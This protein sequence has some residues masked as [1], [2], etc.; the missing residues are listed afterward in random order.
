MYVWTPGFICPRRAYFI[1]YLAVDSLALEAEGGLLALVHHLLE[2]GGLAEG[3]R[4]RGAHR[5]EERLAV[6]LGEQD[7]AAGLVMW[8]GWGWCVRCALVPFIS[9]TNGLTFSGPKATRHLPTLQM[10]ERSVWQCLKK[11]MWKTGSASLMCP[12]WPAQSVSFRLA[13]SMGMGWMGVRRGDRR[14]PP[15][16][17]LSQSIRR[18]QH[19]HQSKRTGNLLYALAGGAGGGLVRHA[20]SRVQGRVGRRRA[21]HR[22]VVIKLKRM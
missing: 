2:D 6:G 18:I 8:V 13:V 15:L 12:K 21:L 20:Q 5:P 3:V 9:S 14:L 17:L 4:V 7:A 11:P 10:Q 22:V 1:T 19:H 16:L